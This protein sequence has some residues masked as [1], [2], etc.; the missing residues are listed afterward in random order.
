[1]NYLYYPGCSLTSTGKGYGESIKAVFE[2][3]GVGLTEIDDW[4]CCGAT[5]YMAVDECK[6]F[7]LAARNLALAE[8]QGKTAET[9]QPVDV[10]APCSACYLVLT[11]TQRYLET[12]PE[13]ERVVLGALHAA[14]LE[15]NGRVRVRHPIDVLVNDVK[16]QRISKK[17][18]KPLKGM[19]VAC[20]YGCQF[21]RPFATFDDPHNPK[22][23]E[24]IVS[25]VGA[26]PLKWPLRTRCCGASLTGTIHEV[27]VELS[28]FI[29]QE[30]AK[31]GADAIITACSLCQFNLE[32][33]Q[34]EMRDE[35]GKAFRVPV[36]YFTQLLGMAMGLS[37]EALGMKRLFVPFARKVPAQEGG[38]A[39]HV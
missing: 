4:N 1:M 21:L 11:K 32:C 24:Q 27:G 15:Y 25:A 35:L 6:A 23:M 37:E 39:A 30:A 29:L 38:Q 7:A 3:L 14:G 31:R 5:A 26:E 28:S 36:M 19:K 10:V 17:V 9:G 34:K 20:Y 22:T 33:Y 16:P 2:A 18:T 12:I 13:V 8:V